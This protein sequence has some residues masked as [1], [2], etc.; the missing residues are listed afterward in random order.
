MTGLAVGHDSSVGARG[1]WRN[2]ATC[3][4]A[5]L[6]DFA[7][8]RPGTH[9]ADEPA[10]G[11]KDRRTQ[12]Q[13][14]ILAGVLA[15][16]GGVVDGAPQSSENEPSGS[17][18]A[19]GTAGTAGT[20]GKGPGPSHPAAGTGGSSS[21]HEESFACGNGPG[22]APTAGGKGG[23]GGTDLG[24]G[25]LGEGGFCGGCG[26]PPRIVVCRSRRYV[27]DEY[28]EEPV[29]DAEDACQLVQQHVGGEGG[30]G[31]AAA[32]FCETYVEKPTEYFDH[33]DCVGF[34]SESRIGECVV[35]GECCVVVL[36][37]G[38]DE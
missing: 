28:T 7:L 24:L 17:A 9:F 2:L 15:A 25:G 12:R 14:L 27:A 4:Y 36:S 29:E 10:M 3:D 31:G 22:G 26:T 37:E 38:C 33:G 8:R 16:C 30:A 1:T 23:K 35:N 11:S 13:W 21:E 6:R 20:S 5:K 19:S 18:S 32:S 34:E